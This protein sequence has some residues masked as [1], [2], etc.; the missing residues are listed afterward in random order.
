MENSHI[1]DNQLNNQFNIEQSVR[2]QQALSLML[3][4]VVAMLV[5]SLGLCSGGVI[6]AF[7][8]WILAGIA[9]A[10]ALAGIILAACEQ[11]G[12]VNCLTAALI[13]QIICAGLMVV[14]MIVG[15]IAFALR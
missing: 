12:G 7:V 15:T 8:F 9:F 10:T 3:I 11:L 1:M 6:P 13:L 5:L 4:P 14:Q 2:L